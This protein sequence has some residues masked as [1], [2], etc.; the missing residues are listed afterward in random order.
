MEFDMKIWPMRQWL[1]ILIPLEFMFFFSGCN[2]VVDWENLTLH[3]RN[4][5]L[6]ILQRRRKPIFDQHLFTLSLRWQQ[7]LMPFF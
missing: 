7:H 4:D 5:I 6:K 3:K 1:K 2:K